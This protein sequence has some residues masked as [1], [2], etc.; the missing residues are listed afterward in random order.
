MGGFWDDFWV[1]FGTTIIITPIAVA[2]WKWWEHVYHWR[3]NRWLRRL[4]DRHAAAHGGVRQVA[5]ALSVGDD[6]LESVR[7]HLKEKGLL[8]G[9]SDIPIIAVHEPQSFGPSEGQWYSYLERVKG[10]IRKIRN[11]GFVRVHV[12]ARL[13]VAQAL[14]VGATL[15]NGPAAVV[16]HFQNG[17]YEVVGQVTFEVTKL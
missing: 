9:G 10:E 14:M 2:L 8:G 11:E 15:T 13:P 5:L 16:Y 1:R 17:R 12:Y 3:Y 4:A 7:G 6:I